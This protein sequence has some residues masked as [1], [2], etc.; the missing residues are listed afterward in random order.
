VFVTDA[1]FDIA[2]SLGVDTE[3]KKE[4]EASREYKKPQFEFVHLA[5]PARRSASEIERLSGFLTCSSD[6]DVI[7]IASAPRL[8]GV[9]Q[10]L[11]L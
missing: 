9:T 11:R 7:G 10:W 6:P 1:A 2:A 4:S 5:S 8:P 3:T